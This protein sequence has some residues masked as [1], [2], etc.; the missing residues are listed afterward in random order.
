MSPFPRIKRHLFSFSAAVSLVL[1]LATAALWVRSSSVIDMLFFD[2][3]AR[4]T[5]TAYDADMS[6]KHG[7]EADVTLR[8]H[9]FRLASWRG[10]LVLDYLYQ[11]SGY[12][13]DRMKSAGLDRP[14]VE[15]PRYGYSRERIGI[16][17]MHYV[18][19]GQQWSGLG[20]RGGKITRSATD[21]LRFWCIPMYVPVVATAFLP[22]A[23]LRRHVR[24]RS[25]AGSCMRCGYD[26]RATPDRCPECGALPKQP[27]ETAA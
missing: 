1:C 18:T 11:S 20:F 14:S 2:R 5:V 21:F 6:R 4:H 16:A 7:Y 12:S 13:W 26:L 19:Y 15:G 3:W 17:S 8:N 24:R 9:R 10:A 25:R 22:T 23:W 27:A